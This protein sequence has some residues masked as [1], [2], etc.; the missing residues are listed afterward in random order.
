MNPIHAVAA[1]ALALSLA[2][3]SGGS[4]TAPPVDPAKALQ[5]GAA[6]MAQL[7]SVSATLKITKGTI[8]VQS[9]PLVSA[10]TAVELPSDSDTFYTVKDQ[11]VSISLEVVISG[12]HVYLRVPFSSYREVSGPDAAMLPDL[13]KL[14]DPSTGLPAMIP[15]GSSPKYVST[16]Q[17]DGR[18]AYQIL[19]AYTPDQVHSLLPEL[20][21]NTAVTARIWVDVSD[22]LIH[23]AVLEGAFGDGGKDAALEVDMTGFDAPVTINSPTP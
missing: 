22:H 17:V 20:T 1:A 9:F 4:Q 3:C 5:D 8:T 10:R 23:K 7:K 13:A 11:D 18:S 16:D 6:A 12:G 21:S 14:F 15:K 19:T 2:A